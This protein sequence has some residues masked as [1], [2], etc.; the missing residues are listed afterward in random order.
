MIASTEGTLKLI[1]QYMLK[2]VAIRSNKKNADTMPGV[3]IPV[4]ATLFL[5]ASL[6][7]S[8][9][10]ALS[11]SSDLLIIYVILDNTIIT[12][13]ACSFGG[14]GFIRIIGGCHDRLPPSCIYERQDDGHNGEPRL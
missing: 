7:A 5:K 12:G 14:T 8:L 10:T 3:Q 1:C 9:R 6:L 13:G 11:R 2:A 4:S